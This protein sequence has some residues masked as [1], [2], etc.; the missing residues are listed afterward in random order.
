MDHRGWGHSSYRDAIDFAIAA[1]VGYQDASF[2]GRLFRRRV[3][4]TPARYRKRFAAMRQALQ[5]A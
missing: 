4:L 1:E 5:P 3:E 2:F